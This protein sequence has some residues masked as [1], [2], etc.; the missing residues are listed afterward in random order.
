MVG[1]PAVRIRESVTI[2]STVEYFRSL[3]FLLASEKL[4]EIEFH[5][6]LSRL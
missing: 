2:E 4:F 6:S 1:K 3:I 5:F